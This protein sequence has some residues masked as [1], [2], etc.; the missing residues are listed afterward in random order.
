MYDNT[1]RFCA[2]EQLANIFLRLDDNSQ[3]RKR[4][5]CVIVVFPLHDPRH[6]I[7]REFLTYEIGWPHGLSGQS[8]G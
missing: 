8:R 2:I 3:S 7:P 6:Q 5:P 1:D 4:M